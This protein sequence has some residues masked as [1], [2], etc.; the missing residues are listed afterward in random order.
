MNDNRMSSVQRMKY[1]S[2]LMVL[3]A[4]GMA[5]IF[6][7]SS[8]WE[9]V[10]YLI[11]LM[12]ILYFLYG[13]SRVMTGDTRIQSLSALVLT[14]ALAV[15]SPA[16]A[17]GAAYYLMFRR[18]KDYRHA[19]KNST[20]ADLLRTERGQMYIVLAILLLIATVYVTIKVFEIHMKTRGLN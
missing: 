10:G 4:V 15:I 16:V 17:S 8:P 14:A 12:G 2:R 20:L 13:E 1:Q 3:P 11:V 18:L 9:F 5:E 6:V 7:A 19:Y